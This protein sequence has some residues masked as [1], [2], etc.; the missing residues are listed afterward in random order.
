MTPSE[1]NSVHPPRVAKCPPLQPTRVRLWEADEPSFQHSPLVLKNDFYFRE[2]RPISTVRGSEQRSVLH[3][4]VLL[5][6]HLE[7][8]SGSKV[9]RI[10]SARS[11]PSRYCQPLLI[12]SPPDLK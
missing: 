3:P 8:C 7:V 6:R 2:Y 5:V 12:R 4:S 9:E 11:R 10:F 1:R